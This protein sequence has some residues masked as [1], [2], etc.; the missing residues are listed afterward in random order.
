MPTPE[1]TPDEN[2]Q[3]AELLSKVTNTPLPK[4]EDL[5][6]DPELRRQLR[7]SKAREKNPNGE[8]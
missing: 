1:P 7:E 8:N 6:A 4:G 3:I 2:Q 5:L